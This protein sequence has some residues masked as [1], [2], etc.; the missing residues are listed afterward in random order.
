MADQCGGGRLRQWGA[1][2]PDL[3]ALGV[4]VRG[5]ADAVR[6]GF[7]LRGGEPPLGDPRDE[8]VEVV[9]EDDVPGV[10]GVLGPLLDED[11]PVLGELPHGLGVR[12]DERRRRAEEPF[13]PPQGRRV[14]GDPDS[15]NMIDGHARGLEEA[16]AVSTDPVPLP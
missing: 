7:P 5:L 11:E 8:R 3:V 13:V 2:D 10:P 6:L 9:D 1:A 14:V 16:C 15:R 4:A 12:W